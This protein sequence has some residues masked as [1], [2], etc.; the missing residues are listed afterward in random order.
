MKNNNRREFLRNSGLL[1]L[2]GSRVITD[3]ACST[4]AL[5]DLKP[6]KLNV[7]ALESGAAPDWLQN[8]NMITSNSSGVW[9]DHKFTL[10]P[11]ETTRIVRFRAGNRRVPITEN[12]V[13]ETI[14]SFDSSGIK[15]VPLISHVPHSKKAF[16]E[17][18]K[19]G[20][21][22]TP[23][24]HFKDIHTYYDDQ[25]VF[26]Y[27]NPE[28]LLRDKDGKWAH[29]W[30]D[31]S[32]RFY[33]F[34]T[35]LNN[36]TYVKLS[37]AYVEKLMEWGADGVF[38][39]NVHNRVKECYADKFKQNNPEFEPY[40]HEHIYPDKSQNYAQNRFYE[41]VRN[42]VKSYGNDKIVILNTAADSMFAPN[43]DA[44]LWEGFLF[45]RGSDRKRIS[46]S[47]IRKK[48]ASY[49][50]YQDSGRVVA[51]LSYVTSDHM[52]NAFWGFAAANLVGFTWW[53]GLRGPTAIL[54]QVH[55][56]KPL[57]PLKDENSLSFRIYE[58]GVI[59]LN[60]SLEEK[61]LEIDLPDSFHK[62]QMINV[63]NKNTTSIVNGKIRVTIP[64]GCARVYILSLN[65]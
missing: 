31:R 40:V 42:L 7:D 8:A 3:Y 36:P 10:E 35:C 28:V 55:M 56:K 62:K 65:E 44:A 11:F 9:I 53:A 61:N 64:A 21:R 29:L 46:W 43:S 57:S 13:I 23:Y 20:Y 47:D 4:V 48:A 6:E 38:I 19:Q 59:V 2:G 12:R 5:P 17:A 1:A 26:V 22:V 24:V 58:N 33:R 49:Q 27:D 50:A 30:M 34:L 25:D 37:L 15:G 60:D 16:K 54:Y 32:D 63:F 18:Q 41:Q 14:E 51:T 52:E 39:D 45:S